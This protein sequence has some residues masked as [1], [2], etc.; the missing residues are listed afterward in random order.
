MEM[1]SA[2]ATDSPPLQAPW[3][4]WSSLALSMAL[5]GSYVALSKPLVLIFPVFLLAWL[6]FGIGALAMLHW[7][8][9]PMD[10]APVDAATRRWLFAQSFFGNFLFSICMLYGV[11]MT[12]AV[13]AG[14]VMSTIPAVV[15]VLSA[16]F[17][18]ERM[19]RH[20][21]LAIGLAALGMALFSWGKPDT[22]HHPTAWLGNALVFAAVV[23]EAAY[24]VIGKRLSGHLSPKRIAAIINVWGLVLVTPL[25]WWA[26]SS[27]DFGQ[28]ALSQWTLL[29]FYGLAASVW[30]VWLWMT[31]LQHVPA[32]RAGVFTAVLPISAA[33]VGVLVMGETI[34]A[35]QV[36]GFALSL[37]GLIAVTWPRSR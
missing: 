31:G 19:G 10:E 7:L 14:L 18:R 11:S 33:A 2:H 3:W 34:N 24:V 4:A 5:V 37:S 26:A 30:T 20:T 13:A 29:V 23:C 22:A 8:K 17:L 35:W 28:V 9:R 27:F 12:S 15:A 21:L 25:G 1:T 16:V 6:R 36:A 32:N